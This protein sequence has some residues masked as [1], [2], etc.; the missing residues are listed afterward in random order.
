MNRLLPSLARLSAVKEAPLDSSKAGQ[1]LNGYLRAVQIGSFGAVRSR[2]RR[3]LQGRKHHLV[4][5]VSGHP[6]WVLPSTLIKRPFQMKKQSLAIETDYDRFRGHAKTRSVNVSVRTQPYGDI[7][8]CLCIERRPWFTKW[9]RQLSQS[10]IAPGKQ[11]NDIQYGLK[12][13]GPKLTSPILIG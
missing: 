2:R 4:E 8:N 1:L 3:S 6:R 5:V 13:N 10:R 11:G 9:R 7:K 12:P